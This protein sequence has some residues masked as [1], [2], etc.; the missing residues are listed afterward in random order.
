MTPTNRSLHRSSLPIFHIT[1]LDLFHWDTNS[2]ST[3]D[4]CPSSIGSTVGFWIFLGNSNVQTDMR[5]VWGE[6]LCW[7]P[8]SATCKDTIPVVFL[9]CKNVKIGFCNSSFSTYRI[10]LPPICLPWRPDTWKQMKCSESCFLL[11]VLSQ[12]LDSNLFE[13][14]EYQL[15]DLVCLKDHQECLWDD[16]LVSK[17]AYFGDRA[18]LSVE[19]GAEV[20]LQRYLMNASSVSIL[21]SENKEA[22][23]VCWS[24]SKCRC[25]ESKYK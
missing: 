14:K 7:K 24:F 21:F 23:A 6:G 16:A 8:P 19:A 17:G 10:S 4:Y 1:W 20:N 9:E 15:W 12:W 13:F 25:F 22:P 5:T 3:S 11:F 18:L 2:K